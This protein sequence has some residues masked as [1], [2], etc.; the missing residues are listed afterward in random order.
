[1]NRG[2][3][4][5]AHK[6]FLD[7]LIEKG[8]AARK[9]LDENKKQCETLLKSFKKTTIRSTKRVNIIKKLLNQRLYLLAARKSYLTDKMQRTGKNVY[10]IQIV[11]LADEMNGI[12]KELANFVY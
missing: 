9:E 3:I 12:S 5:K 1:M 8:K 4:V 10:N 7:Q 11:K 2:T 6:I